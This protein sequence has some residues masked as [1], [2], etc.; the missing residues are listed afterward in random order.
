MDKHCTIH[1][2][3]KDSREGRKDIIYHENFDQAKIDSAVKNITL[4]CAGSYVSGHFIISIFLY[5]YTEI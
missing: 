5:V 3:G 2:T 4:S 1:W